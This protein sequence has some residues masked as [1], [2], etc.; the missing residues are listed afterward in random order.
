M[1]ERFALVV[2]SPVGRLGIAA[3][4][5]GVTR[6]AW[7]DA[8]AREGRA[9]PG[10]ARV[11]PARDAR[12]R[13]HADAAARAL[14]AYFAREADAA[15]RLAA[16]PLVAVGSAFAQAVWCAL[17]AIAPG[18]THHYGGVA[19]AL[20]S[21]GAARAVGAAARRN[22][23]AIAIPCHRLV[24]A[25]GSLTGFAGGLAAKRWLL[26]HEGARPRA[27]SSVAASSRSTNAPPTHEPTGIAT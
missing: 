11:E 6:V 12:A 26:E 18:A 17:R 8:P 14:A 5:R 4:T 2:D 10:S 3:E 22:P 27:H 16:L 13:R 7:L 23:I 20:G 15:A 19:R 1:E 24:G 21:P 25:D 9:R